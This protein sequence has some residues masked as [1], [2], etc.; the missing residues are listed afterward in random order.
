MNI[1]IKNALKQISDCI[2][3]IIPDWQD[4]NKEIIESQFQLWM[5]GKVVPPQRYKC[6][7]CGEPIFYSE[8]YNETQKIKK[9]LKEL[10]KK[11]NRTAKEQEEMARLKVL[12][13]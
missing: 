7:C 13:K 11:E 5:A 12:Y 10:R 3:T 8:Q 4:L 2:N 9:R 1:D 6:P